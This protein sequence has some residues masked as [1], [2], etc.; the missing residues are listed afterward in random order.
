MNVYFY[1]AQILRSDLSHAE[2]FIILNYSDSPSVSL[3][4][5]SGQLRLGTYMISAGLT[6]ASLVQV[7]RS[8]LM[9]TPEKSMQGGPRTARRA[10]HLLTGRP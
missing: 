10:V 4:G 5:G 3:L 1:G 2:Q 8:E 9:V 7:L 6:S